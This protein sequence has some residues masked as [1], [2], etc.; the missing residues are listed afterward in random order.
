[1]NKK[2]MLLTFT[3]CEFW[4]I[5]CEFQKGV[6]KEWYEKVKYNIWREMYN[7]ISTNDKGE[8]KLLMSYELNSC[9]IPDI[10]NCIVTIS[11]LSNDEKKMNYNWTFYS[12]DLSFGLYIVEKFSTDI[13]SKESFIPDFWETDTID[14]TVLA[15]SK[16]DCFSINTPTTIDSVDYV[17]DAVDSFSTNVKTVSD[18]VKE[19]SES[20]KN[21]NNNMSL[22]KAEEEKIM[23]KGFNFEFG[24]LTGYM[25]KMSIYGLAVRNKENVYVSY[26]T[27]TQ[28]LVDVDV[29]QFDGSKF[30]YKMPVAIKDIKLG[31][32]VVHQNIPMFVVD[33]P[34]DGKT[35]K[36]VDPFNGERKEILLTR[37]PFGFNFATKV[38]NFLEGM[39]TGAAAPTAENPFGNMWM[40]ALMG[41][42]NG[43]M[44]KMLPLM[45]M[46]QSGM[47]IDP[48][49]MMFMIQ[50]H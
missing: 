12:Y 7:T 43:D 34:V 5:L 38:V 23:I 14:S 13:W 26:N 24:P 37:S 21:M 30:L 41:E 16:E 17:I 46:N 28:E 9:G 25:A 3:P 10:D 48:M 40:L 1:M 8:V 20:I 18:T 22:I 49:M 31:D 42:D 45:M 4:N 27:E 15:T 33:I 11:F 6:E 44:S 2:S 39:M 29:F 19:L 47:N 50:I 35:L 32:V 36:V